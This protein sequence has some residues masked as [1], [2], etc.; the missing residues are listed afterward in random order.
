MARR[1]VVSA[2]SASTTDFPAGA[3]RAGTDPSRATPRAISTLFPSRNFYL[4]LAV[5]T[6]TVGRAVA[7]H[8]LDAEL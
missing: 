1:P 8:P 4:G 3:G 7:A 2:A 5:V 6:L